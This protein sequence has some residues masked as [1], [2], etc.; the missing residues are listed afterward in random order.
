VSII[1]DLFSLKTAQITAVV[2]C[3]AGWFHTKVVCRGDPTDRDAFFA[4]VKNK[5]AGDVD[6]KFAGRLL[7]VAEGPNLIFQMLE[8]GARAF[9]L[10]ENGCVE[11]ERLSKQ[12]GS[13]LV[14]LSNQ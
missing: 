10:K 6:L 5:S 12:L 4:S 9:V 8:F 11:G 14:V 7:F 13:F 1:H 2:V 3:L